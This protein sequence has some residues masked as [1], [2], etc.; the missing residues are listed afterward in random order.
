MQAQ[1][2]PPE[3]VE[4]IKPAPENRYWV[5]RGDGSIWVLP[6]ELLYIDGARDAA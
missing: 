3:Y 2:V 4:V 5:K 6:K 1:T